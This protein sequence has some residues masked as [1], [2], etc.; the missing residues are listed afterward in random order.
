MRRRQMTH[1]PL[2]L[3]IVAVIAMAALVQDRNVRTWAIVIGLTSVAAVAYA[4]YQEQRATRA[5]A[6]ARS[7]AGAA[8][9]DEL[10]REMDRARRHERPFAIARVR[11]ASLSRTA[12]LRSMFEPMTD[13]HLRVALRSTD[14]SWKRGGDL[15][16][17]L[18]ETSALGADSGLPRA[19]RDLS[20]TAEDFRVVSFPADGVTIGGLFASLGAATPRGEDLVRP[21]PIPTTQV[22]VPVVERYE[23]PPTRTRP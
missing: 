20:E 12:D 21:E 5:V 15:Y 19:L 16:F 6:I 23:E 18:P 9:F 3:G 22:P 13:G 2:I 7:R 14:R 8:P 17:L 10:T 1:V 4:A 11:P